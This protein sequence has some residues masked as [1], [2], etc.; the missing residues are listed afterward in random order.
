MSVY[1]NELDSDNDIIRIDDNVTEYGGEAIN[2]LRDAVFAIEKELGKKPSG[3]VN[4]VADRLNIFSDS[5]GNLKTSALAS[6]G[7]V[8]LPISD[9]Q[10][11]SNAGI[12]ESKL[13]LAHGTTDLFTLITSNKT[14]LDSVNIFSR[15]LD[16]N[17]TNHLNG[18]S[19]L[20]DGYTSARHVASHIDLNNIPNDLRDNGFSWD[21]LKDKLGNLREV[22]NVAEALQQINDDLVSHENSLLK[23]HLASSIE[24]DTSNFVEIPKEAD[25]IQKV[26][27]YLDNAEELNIGEHRATQHSNEI[28]FSSRSESVYESGYGYENII[29]STLV[30]AYLVNY[31]AISPNDSTIFGDDIIKFKPD[32]SNF[33]FDSY[34]NKIKVGDILNINYG[35]GIS[36]SF[37]IES[38]RFAPNSDWTVRINGIN[39]A[40]AVDGY[41]DGYAGVAYARVDRSQFDTNTYGVLALAEANSIP[42][43]LYP[44]LLGSVI[45]GNPRSA[46][47]L[48]LAF[49][50]N[51]LN[52][53]HYKLWLQLYPTGNPKDHVI[54]LP[55]ID[56][57]GDSGSTPGSYTLEKIVLETNNSFR[58]IGY[59]FRFIAFEHN[60]NFGIMLSDCINNASF[61]ILKGSSY[62]LNVVDDIAN[63]DAFG[64]G[65]SYTNIAS[66][67]YSASFP[68]STA[69]QNST[70]IILP[71]KRRFFVADGHKQDK[72]ATTYLSN[73]D[74]YW[75]GTIISKTSTGSSVEVG[76]RINLD[77]R[78]AKLKPGKTITIQPTVSFSDPLY[79]NNDYGRFI[80]KDVRF[81]EPCG[82]VGSYTD[83][84]VIS[85][86]HAT[87]VSISYSSDPG[88]QVKM[89]FGEDSVGFDQLNVIDN[90]VSNID[91]HRYHEIY[92]TKK[93][94]TF[95]HE[96]ARLI[97]QNETVSLLRTDNWHVKSVSAKLR[98]YADNIS[99]FN[100]YIRFYITRYDSVSG[101]FDGFIAK[102]VS[103]G[104]G[105]SNP[106]PTITSRKGLVTKFFDETYTDYI[107][108]EFKEI[109]INPGIDM[110]SDST[111]RYVDIELF[112]TMR[113]NDQNLLIG[114]CEIN[115]SQSDGQYVVQ[116][117]KDLREFGS[118]G[119]N[120]F[121]SS[122]VE[123]ISSADKYLHENGIIQGLEYIKTNGLGTKTGQLFFNGG[124]AN[125]NG[126]I[127]SANNTSVVIPEISQDGIIPSIVD[128][129][130]CVNQFGNLQPILLTDTKKQFFAGTGPSYFVPSITFE[131]LINKRKDL[132]IIATVNA[133]ISSITINDN[134]VK[135]CR[136]LLQSQTDGFLTLSSNDFTSGNFHDFK[137][138]KTW[139]NNLKR[140]CKVILKGTFNITE[141]IDLTG[142]NYPVIFQGDGCI[143]NITTGKGF[144]LGSNITFEDITFIYNPTNVAYVDL[145]DNVNSGNGC[146]YAKPNIQINDININKCTFNCTQSS[147]NQRP[148][149]IGFELSKGDILNRINIKKNRFV[150]LDFTK[151]QSAI[152]IIGL[153]NGISVEPA[154]L[155]NC[156][157]KNNICNKVQSIILTT[158]VNVSFAI[159]NVIETWQRPGIN[160][161]HNYICGN[162]CGTIGYCVS[163]LQHSQENTLTDGYNSFCSLMI[164]DNNVNLI[165][166]FGPTGFM[167]GASSNQIAII[168][169]GTGNVLI[170]NNK[171][172]WIQPAVA[173]N[174]INKEKGSVTIVNNKLTANDEGYLAL[175]N[176]TTNAAIY[177]IGKN[178]N[179]S[180]NEN[181]ITNIIGNTITSDTIGKTYKYGTFVFSDA[182]IKDN[183]ISGIG[184][185]GYGMLFAPLTNFHSR[186][187]VT[188]NSI[189]RELTTTISAYI[190]CLNQAYASSEA[191]ITNNSFNSLYVDSANTNTNT[192]TGYPASWACHTNKNQ[193]VQHVFHGREGQW[194]ISS[195]L[196]PG[197][198]ISGIST[199]TGYRILQDFTTPNKVTYGYSTTGSEAETASWVIPL[200]SVL[201]YGVKIVNLEIIG[202]ISNTASTRNLTIGLITPTSGKDALS[203]T[204]IS[205]SPTKYTLTGV[206]AST[207]SII[208]DPTGDY[209]PVAY[210]TLNIANSTSVN[211]ELTMFKITYHW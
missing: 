104:T 198:L 156:N 184:E 22:N 181:P 166:L 113:T 154:V 173:N 29:P 85:G 185:N 120:N 132:T 84:T 18:S 98:G 50:V 13:S 168:N 34:F 155:A 148:P 56:V 167:G 160:S 102:R 4:S 20:A 157:I 143:L 5:N 42:N 73:S 64:F 35:N 128:W 36:A 15:L 126:K 116:F 53:S 44:N 153:Q 178:L 87:G 7:L 3:S 108:L 88:L 208:S 169:Y 89:Y 165:G 77:L 99:S 187:N 147:G 138:V 43:N 41:V 139:I 16:A 9:N 176:S 164:S 122:A 205:T 55:P 105:Y 117:V 140:S 48:G 152:A 81:T 72:F 158:V 196:N 107:E 57:T 190:G 194:S 149:F 100:K 14:L 183:Y 8:T 137:V 142:F 115:W 33:L 119:A 24:I 209:I 76:Y 37:E 31:P 46:T 45:V 206:S 150:D 25:D 66:V 70:K 75:P 180:S 38:T 54:N 94:Q 61:A 19:L 63:F 26:V 135:D 39:L 69:A 204:G 179:N 161:I 58:K 79:S 144:L 123:F 201:P 65:S 101:E 127:I 68:D 80:I 74:G 110:L 67:G 133:H 199:N 62:S 86:V 175:Y 171:A 2:Q 59:N 10:V 200:L 192:I 27:N 32:N 172:N 52:S 93:G 12:K 195:F 211:T 177:V 159:A 136:K 95:S 51:K 103:S 174:N 114:S 188:G 47:A 111:S 151:D 146:L 197:G 30:N 162:L 163:G 83:I 40:N 71:A 193:I 97:N 1:P 112:P 121:N 129:A 134:D 49:D 82:N 207:A 109:N 17:F 78:A 210:V 28:L 202:K 21:G 91:Y 145:L 6:V 186:Y 141:T 11:G 131:E 124:I 191:L 92:I 23:A 125:V 203:F 96:R 60:D 170:E 90:T 106:G 189:Y 130:V 118:I 182:S